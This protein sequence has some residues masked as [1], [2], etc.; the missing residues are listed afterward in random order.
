M[1]HTKQFLIESMQCQS[2]TILIKNELLK[3]PGISD[4]QVNY[5]TKIA[6]VS[7]DTQL[8]NTSQ[9]EEIMSSLGYNIQALEK[10]DKNN[11]KKSHHHEQEKLFFKL[12]VS[13]SISIIL[14]I[15]TMLPISPEILKNNMFQ[16]ILASIVQWWAGS[17]FILRAWQALKR[18]MATMDTLIALGSS[19]A[20]FYSLF[21]VLFQI[22]F[23][24]AG[25]IHHVYHIYFETS[26]MIISLI[27]LGKYLEFAAQSK[28]S[29]AIAKLMGLQ[30]KT[31]TVLQTNHNIKNSSK[32]WQEVPIE[33][34]KINDIIL[35]KPGEQIPTDGIIIQGNAY[36]NESMITG[37]SIPVYKKEHDSVIGSTIITSGSIEIKATKI[38]QG[39][40]LAK[41]IKTVHEAQISRAPIEQLT[42][43]ISAIFVPIVMLLALLAFLLW[44]NF[45]PEPKFLNALISLVS[46]LIIA[47]PC[48]LGLAIPTSIMV[49]VG[50]AARSGIIIKTADSLQRGAHITTIIFDKTGTLT[51]GKR[52]VSDTFYASQLSQQE[53]SELQSYIMS[54]EQHST[55][56]VSQ[57]IVRFLKHDQIQQEVTNFKNFPGQGVS[58]EINNHKI[59]IGSQSLIEQNKITISESFENIALKWAQDAK[60]VSFVGL[61][62]SLVSIFAISDIVK[63]E[64]AVTI[65]KLKTLG[66]TTHMIT[67]DN[68]ICA[69]AV[70]KK[71]TIE[72][73]FV[74]SQILPEQKE[75]Y[76]KAR[77]E[78]HEVVAMIG[79]GI[80]DAPALASADIGIAMGEGSDIAIETADIT[81][82]KNDL[83]LI[84]YFL[85]LSK[86][87]LLNIK[88]NLAW[89]FGYNILLI[90]LAMG[91]LYPWFG[92]TFNP[93]FASAAM[94]F[95]SL[96]V[97]LNALRL[98]RITL[99][100]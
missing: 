95:S 37:E 65:Q 11:Q 85:Y 13:I 67:G 57:A 9:I 24:D 14:I 6:T 92:I 30:A 53:V 43:S 79:D 20:Y 60:T 34:I 1:I 10:K 39:T 70:A 80:N 61:D 4:A 35:A 62:N 81:L 28:A 66:I 32:N 54:L 59:I 88:E 31:A 74:R 50:Q 19:V 12:I 71:V 82:L 83:E 21:I 100:R 44:F 49:A 93:M 2:C 46:V 94:S 90:P 3:Q 84:P 97:V 86:R 68:P 91:I 52:S 76:I 98:K 89:A 8:I 17:S 77:Q 42:D 58:G 48:A 15:G 36:I 33:N 56:P 55:H 26:A 72:K 73:K 5:A 51:E 38:G 18:N 75:Q 47:C 78:K 23:I 87:T 69:Q 22:L 16:L 25:Q 29:E 40:L 96:S 41:I 45:G 7:F 64:A 27:L 99:K 63:P